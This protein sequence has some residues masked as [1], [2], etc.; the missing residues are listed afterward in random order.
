LEG[1]GE[2]REVRGGGDEEFRALSIE[3]TLKT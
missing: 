3:G 1:R 2:W